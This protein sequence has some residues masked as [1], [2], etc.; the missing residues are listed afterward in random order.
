MIDDVQGMTSAN[1]TKK[2]KKNEAD[3]TKT[4]RIT[5]VDRNLHSSSS[6][7]NGGEVTCETASTVL[8]NWSRFTNSVQI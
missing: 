8:Q 7:A 5:P 4:Y 3:D 2:C 1:G 6:Y